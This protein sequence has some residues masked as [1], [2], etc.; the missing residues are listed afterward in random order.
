[1]GNTYTVIPHSIEYI[2]AG[3]YDIV[4]GLIPVALLGITAALTFVGL[5]VTTA[6]PAGAFVAMA[7]IGHAMF[8]N[9][10]VDSA[11]DVQS[12]HQPLNAD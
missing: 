4:L 10:P 6:I 11:E 3:Y 1:M 7:L 2:M 9:A 5:S 12:T 8:V